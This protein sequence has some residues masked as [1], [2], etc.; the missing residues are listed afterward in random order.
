M[1]TITDKDY[2]GL[3]V[4]VGVNWDLPLTKEKNPKVTDTT[5][6]ETVKETINYLS[7]QGARVVLLSH[8]G[9][10]KGKVKKELSLKA[11]IGPA[12]EILGKKI[13]FVNDC[14]GDK[15]KKAVKSMKNGEI[16]L[17]ENVRFHSEETDYK[18]KNGEPAEKKFAME[19]ATGYDEFVEDAFARCHRKAASTVG[20]IEVGELKSACGFLVKNEIENLSKLLKADRDSFYAIIGG[21]KVSDKVGALRSLLD[22]TS[23][24]FIGGAMSY[25]FMVAQGQHVG[26]SKVE[27]DDIPLAKDILKMAQEKGVEILLPIDH[28]SGEMFSPN[29][30]FEISDDIP[31]NMMGM[32]IGPKTIELYKEKLKEAKTIFW[33]GPMGV[34]EFE[35]TSKGT[36][37]IAKCVAE[38]EGGF[39]GVGGGTVYQR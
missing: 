36:F 6:I 26:T 38:M 30:Q 14:V 28:V 20:V 31:D 9:R 39:D 3:K 5:R 11:A 18:K 23:K 17:L 8:L 29:T 12:E 34:F 16:L 4:L 2:K 22:H 10:P 19:L 24:L 33:N 21:A 32:D 35:E 7:N 1:H 15:V 25:P 37:E 13:K 27:E